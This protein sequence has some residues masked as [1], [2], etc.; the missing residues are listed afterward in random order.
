MKA[1]IILDSISP[2]GIR[3]TTFE[4]KLH[5]FEL[6]S[7]NTHRALSRNSSSNRAIPNS[8]VLKEILYDLAWPVFWGKNKAGMQ[9]NEELT[10]IKLA[11]VKGIWKIASIIAVGLSYTLSKLG[12]HKQL[13][14]R[15]IEPFSWTRTIVT[16]TEFDNFFTL[17]C[18]KDAQPEIKMLA[19]LMREEYNKSTPILLDYNEWHLPYITSEEKETLSLE[20]CQKISVARCARVSYLNHDG[21]QTSK[22]KDFELYN[23]LVGGKIKHSSPCEHQA[24]P[25]RGWTSE[26]GV[27]HLTKDQ[28]NWFGN[29]NRQIWSGNF[30]GWIQYRQLI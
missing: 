20:E 22:E 10:G 8:K 18:D 15:L 27:T 17:R 28:D 21:K 26:K 1:K 23:R 19:E 4:L 6:A 12:L 11:L 24:K 30:R 25:V 14:N 7:F 5:R 9:A 2:D 29:T 16:A 13:C 3:L